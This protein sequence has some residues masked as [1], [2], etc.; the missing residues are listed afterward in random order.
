MPIQGYTP[1]KNLVKIAQNS[2]DNWDV[3]QNQNLDT[4]DEPALV[5]NSAAAETLNAGSVAVIKD[6]GTG[7]KKAYLATVSAYIP[8][9]PL[10]VVMS[11]ATAGAP[12]RL[13]LAGRVQNGAWSFGP[14][15]KFAY[16]SS[17]GTVTF[18]V[19][20]V[21]LGY[22]L[23]STAIYFLPLSSSSGGQTDTVAGA[24][25]L[26]NTGNNINAVIAPTY[27]SAVNTVCQGNDVR[28]HSQNTDPGTSAASFEINY[29]ANSARLLTT[30]LTANRDYTLPDATTKLV[31]ESSPAT[32][33]AQHSFA[34]AT[35]AAPFALG[36]NAQ[37][38]LVTGLNADL[39]DGNHAAAFATSGHNHSGVY[40]PSNANIQTHIGAVAPHSGHEL[41]AN[42]AVASGYPSLDGSSKVVQDPANATATPTANKIPIADANGKLDGWITA[43]GGGAPTTASYLTAQAEA[44]LSAETNLGALTTGLLK[45]SVAGGV[46]TPATAIAGADYLTPASGATTFAP[47][48]KGVTNGDSHDHNGGDG[49]AIAL[50]TAAVSGTLPIANGGTGQ[51][52]ANAA[53]NALLPTQTSNSGKVLTSDGANTSWATAPGVAVFKLG[54]INGSGIVVQRTV[55]TDVIKN[56][57]ASTYVFGAC[58]RFTGAW[59]GSACTAGS[60][61]QDTTAAVG[62]TGYAHHFSGVTLTGTGILYHR[63]RIESLIAK[64]YKNQSCSLSVKVLHD[65]GS[66][67]NFTAYLRKP[68]TTADTFSAVTEIANSGQVSIASGASGWLT[69]QNVSM[70]DCSKGIEI[71]I[72]AEVGAI[73]A[74]NLRLTEYQFEIGSIA[75]AF[76]FE[77]YSE[78]LAKCLRYYLDAQGA[79]GNHIFLHGYMPGGINYTFMIPFPVPMRVAP[80]V[81]K[82]GTW[83]VTNCGQPV[84]YITSPSG[85]TLYCTVTALAMMWAY[86]G[87]AAATGFTAS[88]EL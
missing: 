69:F 7:A 25:G 13:V 46:S 18:A 51:S 67:V 9:D 62:R 86:P 45:H 5:Y 34:P 8:G 44:G 47:I 72:K 75:T 1:N 27:G 20:S 68:T 6:D 87:G 78:T 42:K 19:T 14:A 35:P 33:T 77:S 11:A 65:V 80:T 26:L 48:A 61:N 50:A 82:S 41:T 79:N 64:N 15:N 66:A 29:T 12:V 83:T 28:L 63:H 43:G 52:T 16:L 21:K 56:A 81:T 36:A 17:S 54:V 3:W 60:L 23:S 2:T 71:E 37:G 74:K 4:L 76:E 57:A 10:G 49:A 40:E 70:G 38:Q 84:V 88:A 55:G 73:T 58:D 59:S 31:G 32:I 85:V 53:L 24:N 22:V 39:L 30:G